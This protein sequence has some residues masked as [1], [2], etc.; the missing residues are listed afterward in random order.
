[1]TT[2]TTKSGD[3]FDLIAFNVYG[4][5]AYTAKLIHA[6]TQYG[7]VFIFPAGIVLSVPDLDQ[8]DYDTS[9]IPPWR[10]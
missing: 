3:M 2:Y 9:Y 6:N 1:M 7:S 4:N 5:T 8:N 10:R